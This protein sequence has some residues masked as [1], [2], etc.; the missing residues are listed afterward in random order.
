MAPDNFIFMPMETTTGR[1]L[2][3]GKS[4]LYP[5]NDLKNKW[6][7]GDKKTLYIGKANCLRDRL[8]AYIKWGYNE[9][10]SAHRGGSAI[11]Q[12]KESYNLLVKWEE[13]SLPLEYEKELLEKYYKNYSVYPVA[14]W[15]N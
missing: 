9:S 11:W 4:T 14:N 2:Y 13:H 3:K 5:L 10:G 8:K 6:E 7:S 1:P 12:I 15:R